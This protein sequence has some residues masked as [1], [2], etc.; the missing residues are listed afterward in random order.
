L[1]NLKVIERFSFGWDFPIPGQIL[2]VLGTEHPQKFHFS[3]LDPQK[4]L[5]W[6][7]PRR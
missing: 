3:F 6:A 1:D 4:A 5:P 7:K 2:V